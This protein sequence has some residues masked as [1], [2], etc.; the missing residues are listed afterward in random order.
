MQ[1]NPLEGAWRMSDAGDNTIIMLIQDGYF[2]VAVYDLKDKKFL[3]TTGGTY[4]AINGKLTIQHEFNTMDSTKVGTSAT[5]SYTLQND[6]WQVTSEGKNPKETENWV[7]IA[8]K[9]QAS[10]LAG[11]WRITGREQNGEMTTMRPGAR[12]T[13]KV[14]SGTRF[15]WIAFN[16]E[17]GEFSGTGGGTYTAQNG[18]YTE[19]IEFFSRDSSRVG[20]LLSFNYEV[21]DGNWHH[22]GQSSKGSKVNE[23]WSRI[24]A[25]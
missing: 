14:L 13:L 6:K 20:M 23:I 16:S 18:K 7:R 3:G 4:T 8:E 17:T 22:T 24:S 11:T 9:N 1:T 2:T 21:K 25:D 5:S 19:N 10:P 12:K 15:Q